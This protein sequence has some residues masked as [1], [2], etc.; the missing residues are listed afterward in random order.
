M[1]V[2]HRPCIEYVTFKLKKGTDTEEFRKRSNDLDEKF[3]AD[4]DGFLSRK[5]LLLHDG[6]TWADLAFWRDTSAAKGAEA[7]F[8]KDPVTKAYGDLI[9]MGTLRM[10]HSNEISHF[11]IRA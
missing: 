9:D 5:L 3:L 10:E 8:M 4:E 11:E 6:E 1:K 2:G 7:K